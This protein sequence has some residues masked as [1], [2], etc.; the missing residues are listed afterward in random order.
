M[1]QS[2]RW[3]VILE[4]WWV[5]LEVNLDLIHP[6]LPPPPRRRRG[7]RSPRHQVS[8]LSPKRPRLRR[9]SQQHPPLPRSVPAF[10]VWELVA[11][12]HRQH[13]HRH[14]LVVSRLNQAA[15]CSHL[16]LARL[17]VQCLNPLLVHYFLHL[18][19]NL[20]TDC[21]R[22]LYLRLLPVRWLDL[23]PVQYLD[24]LLVQ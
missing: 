13:L 10:W 12:L 14:P 9:A 16:L 4:A 11:R 24:P 15:A 1:V 5:A 21:S 7:R 17:P 23:L 6:P 22:R 19:D 2:A 3:V 20:A 18:V 8:L